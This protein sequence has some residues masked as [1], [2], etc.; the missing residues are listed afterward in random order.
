[1]TAE[2]IS[3]VIAM[4]VMI[5]SIL[6]VWVKLNIKL[7]EMEMKILEISHKIEQID[8][9]RVDILAIIE[10]NNDKIYCKLDDLYKLVYQNLKNNNK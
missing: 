1:M 8:Q 6:T 4:L 7:K 9:E 10:K 3:A 5:G 2:L